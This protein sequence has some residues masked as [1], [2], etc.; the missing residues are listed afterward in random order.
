MTMCRSYIKIPFIE[1]KLFQFGIHTG[2]L[3]TLSS[4][5][6]TYDMMSYWH[7]HFHVV[8]LGCWHISPKFSTQ[9][10]PK[11]SKMTAMCP[12]YGHFILTSFAIYASLTSSPTAI[13]L[14]LLCWFILEQWSVSCFF[15]SSSSCNILVYVI[16]PSVSL[17]LQC[18]YPI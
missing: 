15:I 12:L 16:F 8:P 3:I 13:I 2:V 11:T 4:E 9:G 6:L 18:Q 14:L 10:Q 5:K 1:S 17:I 7:H